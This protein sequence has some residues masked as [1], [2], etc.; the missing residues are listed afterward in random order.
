MIKNLTLRKKMIVLYV[1]MGVFTFLALIAG[2]VIIDSV[3][4]GEIAADIH[5]LNVYMIGAA[6]YLVVY[7]VITIII[8]RKLATVIARPIQ[9]LRDVSIS[10]AKGDSDVEIKYEA[11][12]EVGQLAESMRNML[13]TIQEEAKVLRNIA[14]A[15]FSGEITPRSENDVVYLAILD[16]LKNNSHIIKEVKQTTKQINIS[17]NEVAVGAQSLAGGSS[18]Q[19]A[20]IHEFSSTTEQLHTMAKQNAEIS[21]VTLASVLKNT[22][23]LDRNL[24]DMK[25][26]LDAMQ[27]I[28]DSS[29]QIEKVIKV[30]DDIAFQT[31]ILALNAAVE[32]ARAGQHG[33]GFAVVAEEVRELASKSAAAAQET[34]ALIESSIAD[35]NN[36]NQA[37]TQTNENI[38]EMREI[39]TQTE[40]NMKKLN[41]ASLQQTVSIDE[42]NKGISR[43]TSVIQSNTAMSEQ[44]AAAAALMSAQADHLERTVENIRLSDGV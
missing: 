22:Q 24:A 26:M 2:Y 44:S 17:A 7:A 27:T 16:I 5:L 37:V 33:K 39:A 11:K 25:Q 34:S 10:L 14:D 23:L 6:T 28:T 12:D 4:D 30:I 18:E 29:R 36:G 15:D 40:E 1:E 42:I 31:N 20:T 9:Q 38:A 32:A 13:M 21:N 3:L 19:A 41:E 8:G 43:I 35:V